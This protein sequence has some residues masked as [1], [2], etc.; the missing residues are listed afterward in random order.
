VARTP[1]AAAHEKVLDAAMQLMS[2]RGIEATSMDSIAQLSGVSKATVYKHWHDKD[3]LCLDVL[4]RLR[5]AP[6][7]FRSGNPR[8]DLVDL[9]THVA[10]AKRPGR[11]MKLFPKIIGYAASHPTFGRAVQRIAIGPTEAEFTRILSEAVAAGDLAPDVDQDIAISLLFGP[12]MHRKMTR[13]N[14]P[15]GMVKQVVDAFWSGAAKSNHV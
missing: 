15:P 3:A 6:P 4:G 1:S 2:E 8:R 5:D 9:L 14:V 11:L 7:Q 10:R 13:R 12:I